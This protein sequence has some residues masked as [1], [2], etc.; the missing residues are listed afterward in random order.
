MAEKIV[1]KIEAER[2]Q[3]NE[4]KWTPALMKAGWT[5]LPNVLFERQ[6]ALGLDPLDINILLHIASYWWSKESKPHPSKVT[7]AKAIGID[8]R[9]VQRRI[10][11]LERD[12]LIRREERRISRTGSK[13][14]VYHLDGLIEAA[15]PYAL[16]KIEEQKA[17][18]AA[19]AARAQRKGKPKLTLV[20]NDDE[21]F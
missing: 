20:K 15:K 2:L 21:D 9:S 16:E 5:V 4:R 7:I 1:K 12:G 19:R 6:Q 13:T 17:K 11:A 10:A 8:P 3:V 18:A 14:N